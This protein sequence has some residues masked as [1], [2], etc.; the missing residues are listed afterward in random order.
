[1]RALT[2]I[3]MPI[4]IWIGVEGMAAATLSDTAQFLPF[5]KTSEGKMWVIF[6]GRP[7]AEPVTYS[8]LQIS[9]YRLIQSN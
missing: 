7:A 4:G 8:R 2:T 9:L 6:H 3:D 5:R 1:M